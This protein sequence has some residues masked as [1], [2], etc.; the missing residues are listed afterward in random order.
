M[1]F[2]SNTSSS[3]ELRNRSSQNDRPSAIFRALVALFDSN[4]CKFGY[5]AR[6]V[7]AW[8]VLGCSFLCTLT[9]P[10]YGTISKRLVWGVRAL[11]AA[12][13]KGSRYHQHS[14]LMLLGCHSAD[15]IALSILALFFV[16]IVRASFSEPF[17]S[18]TRNETGGFACCVFGDSLYC[19][20]G[21]SWMFSSVNLTDEPLQWRETGLSFRRLH[22]ALVTYG[23]QIIAV[24]GVVNNNGVLTSTSDLFLYNMVGQTIDGLSGGALVGSAHCGFPPQCTPGRPPCPL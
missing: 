15:R 21:S 5:A 1:L 3:S 4:R 10:P 23:P 8:A 11:A 7:E 14:G 16:G 20:G 24:G 17:F 2:R 9:S 12:L 22:H 6:P 18:P 13:N 19:I